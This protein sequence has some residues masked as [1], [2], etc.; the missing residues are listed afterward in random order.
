MFDFTLSCTFYE[1]TFVPLFLYSLF[2]LLCYSGFV[3][4]GQSEYPADDPK[5]AYQ[6]WTMI[7]EPIKEGTKE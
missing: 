5:Y 3:V 4:K 1:Y 2:L 7:R 6:N